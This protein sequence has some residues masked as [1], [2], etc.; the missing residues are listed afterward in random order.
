M[1]SPPSSMRA[2][3]DAVASV[4]A[5]NTVSEALK[6][7]TTWQNGI[8]S[9]QQLDKVI[10]TIGGVLDEHRSNSA[11]NPRTDERVL[12]CVGKLRA[13]VEG[14]KKDDHRAKRLSILDKWGIGQHGGRTRGGKSKS[15]SSKGGKSSKKRKL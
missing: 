6:Q 1:T 11:W 12:E 8:F 13:C 15:S 7:V 14:I 4:S 5:S 3:D 2:H 10:K 9:L